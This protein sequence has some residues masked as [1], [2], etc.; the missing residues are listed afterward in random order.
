[1][2]KHSVPL[3]FI[4]EHRNNSLGLVRL[5]LACLVIVSHSW[6][7]GGFGIEPL[8]E[9]SSGTTLGFFAVTGFFALSGVLVGRSAL[10]SSA[11]SFMAR[12]SMR[13]L[14]GYWVALGVSGIVFGAMIAIARNLDL[15]QSLLSPASGSVRSYLVNN[16]PLSASQYQLGRV[17]D[18]LPYPGA[19]NGSL[20]SLPYEFACY[21]LILLVMKWYLATRRSSPLLILIAAV[22]L[23]L[24]IASNKPG[25][26]FGG[27][28]IP[29]L[30]VLDSRLFFGL[31]VVFLSGAILSA[32]QDKVRFTLLRTVFSVLFV[33]ISLPLGL[34]APWGG[35]ALGYALIGCSY[36]LPRTFRSIGARNDLSYGMYLYGFPVG[37]L[38]V[39]MFPK[40][41]DSGLLLATV[42]IILTVP[43]AAAS[44]F[45]VER[46]FVSSRQVTNVQAQ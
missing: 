1:V 40:S 3:T 27:I 14:P 6:S 19:I 35:I 8:V 26:N 4:L 44:W 32:I 38:L 39:A 5:V 31:W 45:F 7:I 9:L 16:F 12:R 20:W 30:G 21:L 23:T 36:Y 41:L 2:A 10:A 43:L 37:Q 15:R 29:I 22:S 11:S 28:G 18:G 24:A 42:T 17:L 25:P 34:F 13:I 33:L 46:Y